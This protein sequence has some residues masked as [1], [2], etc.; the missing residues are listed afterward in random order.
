V[1]TYSGFSNGSLAQLVEVDKEL[2]DADAVLGDARLNA[3]FN[4]LLEAQLARG[5][6]VARLVAMSR[7][8]H[9]LHVV[10]H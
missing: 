10:L 4:V 2:A 5:I 7:R 3:L 8:A 6:L 1:D 9:V